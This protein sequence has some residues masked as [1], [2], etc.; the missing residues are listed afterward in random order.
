MIMIVHPRSRP[1]RSADFIDYAEENPGKLNFGSPGTQYRPAR[2]RDVQAAAGIDM[3]HVPTRARARADRSVVWA[4]PVD[5]RVDRHLAAAGPGRI[6]AGVGSASTERIAELP[7]LPTIAE[8]GI[9]AIVSACVRYRRAT[10]MPA[11]A[12]QK[13]SASINRALVTKHSAPRSPRAGFRR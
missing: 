4:D 7:D 2:G 1:R 6:G 10:G 11:E 5:V 3:T 8:T 13:I 9:P 12:A